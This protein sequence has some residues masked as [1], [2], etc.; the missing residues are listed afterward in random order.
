MNSATKFPGLTL[1]FA[2]FGSL[3]ACGGGPSEAE[4]VQ[5]CMSNTPNISRESCECAARESK[6]KLSADGYR[7]SVL[8]MQGKSQEAE[9]I[10]S[11]MTTEEQIALL[12]AT[13]N[14]LT[15]CLL[16]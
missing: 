12:G 8:D 1:L 16:E 5:A 10:T 2:A 9:A 11:A 15:T 3:A 6:A 7:A 14:V 13:G 4:F